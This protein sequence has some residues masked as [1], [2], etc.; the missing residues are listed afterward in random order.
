MGL[1]GGTVCYYCLSVSSALVVRAWRLRQVRGVGT[2]AA[3]R[4]PP[5]PPPLSPGSSRCMWRVLPSRCPVS[6]PA[7]TPFHVVC[8]FHRPGPVASQVRAA[9]PLRVCAL[10]LLRRSCPPP[11]PRLVWRTHHAWFRGRAPVGPFRAVRA[12][13]RFLPRSLAPTS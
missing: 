10:T 11:F 4:V 5:V 7:G 8:A 3:S 12:P 13:P 6:S 1:V 9:C 2:S